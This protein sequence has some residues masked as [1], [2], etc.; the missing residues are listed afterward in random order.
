MALLD[1]VL[2]PPIGPGYHS[3]AERRVAAGR[4]A[5]SGT[6][7]WLMLVSCLL[8]GLLATVAAT[9]LRTPDPV[10]VAAREQLIA[11]IEAAEAA[12]DTQRELVDTLQAEIVELEQ[13]AVGDSGSTSSVEI[14]QAG[15]LAG[16]AALTGPG[17]V[18]LLEDAPRPADTAP[19]EPVVRERVNARDVQ[20]IVNA[21]WGAGAEAISVNG[22]RLTSTSAIRFAGQAIIV[23]FRSL[24]PPYEIRAIGDPAALARETT[25]GFVGS[26]LA[27]LRTQVGLPS[28]VTPTENV[29]VPAASRLTTRVGTVVE[30]EGGTEEVPDRSG[31][32]HAS[33]SG[34]PQ[35]SRPSTAR[36]EEA[37]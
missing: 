29:E 1:E 3:A 22:H 36:P 9:T 23:D 15:L 17:T 34:I 18:I 24:A 20:L 37:S 30:E 7:T 14:E 8:L 21:L 35:W 11:R 13:R 16:A 26:Y 5:S 6:R 28:T 2:D 32:R 12:G 19:G 31:S 25:T 27:E 33:S 4:P 10:A